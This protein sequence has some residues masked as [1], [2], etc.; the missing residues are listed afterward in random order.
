MKSNLTLF[1]L[2]LLA[3]ALGCGKSSGGDAGTAS[4]PSK[5]VGKWKGGVVPMPGKENDKA[6]KISQGFADMLRFE[7]K[8]DMT[9]TGTFIGP[10]EGTYTVAGESVTLKVTKPEESKVLPPMVYDIKPDG[11]TMNLRD[12]PAAKNGQSQSVLTKES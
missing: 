3:F 2:L 12:D 11:Q 1:A 10:V 4:T 7:L 8:D 9:F 6:V 5:F